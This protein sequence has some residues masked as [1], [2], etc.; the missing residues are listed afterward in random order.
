MRLYAARSAVQIPLDTKEAIVAG[1]KEM[2]LLFLERNSLSASDIV[3]IQFTITS[4]LQ[5]YNPA[6]ALR[7]SY[8]NLK[9]PLF[10]MQE[11]TISNMM[12]QVI[13]ALIYFYGDDD[14][15]VQHAYVGT[16]SQL[17][18]DLFS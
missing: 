17:R 10:C 4:D 1:V 7:E 5:S 8:P 18:S 15:C 2:A 13:R 14:Y 16:T 3:S 6:A 9:T 11:P 12:P